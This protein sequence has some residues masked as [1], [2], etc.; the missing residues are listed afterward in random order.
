MIITR[1]I[2]NKNIKFKDIIDPNTDVVTDYSYQDLSEAIDT[3]KNL[4]QKNHNAKPGDSALIAT[5]PGK[6]QIALIF[7]CMELSITIIVVDYESSSNWEEGEYIDSKTKTLLPITYFILEEDT[8]QTKKYNLFRK[9][10]DKVIVLQNE[11]LDNTPNSTLW[12][13]KD[14]TVIR[15]TSSGT[16]GTPKL[17]EHTHEFMYYLISRNRKFFDGSV[18]LLFNLNH[19]SSVA[20]Y[21]LPAIMSEKV[22]RMYSIFWTY[23]SKTIISDVNHIMIPYPHY[24][25]RF[26]ANNLSSNSELIVYTLS[27]IKREWLQLIKDKKI[28]D[29]IS[30]FGSNETSG[31]V[32]INKATDQYFHESKY[33]AVD[34][35]YTIN[36]SDKGEFLVTLPYYN[37]TINTNDTFRFKNDNYYHL[38]RNDLI[39]VNGLSVEIVDY[40]NKTKEYLDADLVFDS[41]RNDIYLAVWTNDDDINNKVQAI[42]AYLRGKSNNTHYIS[43]HEVLDLN[44]FVSG[45]KVDQEK[46]RDYFRNHATKKP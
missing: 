2:I 43:N 1:E 17:I 46:L 12:S 35:F 5:Y 18:G 6:M 24:I 23:T 34:D 40:Q 19:G 28:K 11:T 41:V 27:T 37:K 32:L 13:T 10:C 22:E 45:V 20:T 33:K 15:C 14:S 29:V 16:T 21:F 26:L 7:A 36:L 8:N 38:G 9:I 31:P 30:I 4:L 25:S 3:C 39:R 44:N 42:D